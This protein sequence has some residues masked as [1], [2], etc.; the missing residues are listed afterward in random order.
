MYPG[1]SVQ[2]GGQYQNIETNIKKT[3][4]KMRS[5]KSMTETRKVKTKTRTRRLEI[6]SKT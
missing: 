3:K 5:V 4:T 1:S 2:Y 6:E